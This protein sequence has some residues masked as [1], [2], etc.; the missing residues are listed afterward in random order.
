MTD[1][2]YMRQGLDFA[3]G[4]AVEE[5]GE[6]QAA[7]GKT[8]RWGW[9]SYNPELPP[10]QRE[11]NAAWVAREIKDVRQALDNL[12][13]EMGGIDRINWTHDGRRVCSCGAAEPEMHEDFCVLSV[14]PA[15]AY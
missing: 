6:L 4:K 5:L 14:E 10:A 13:R 2:K 9:D 3:V 8:L 11:S 7:L 1:P 15:K 12:E